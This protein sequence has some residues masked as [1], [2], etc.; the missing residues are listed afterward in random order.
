M[1]KKTYKELQSELDVILEKFETSA[2]DDID[3]MLIDYEQGI[4]LITELEKNLYDAELK[5][6]KMKNSVQ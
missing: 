1:S 4:T 2:H 6:T 5:L 3:E